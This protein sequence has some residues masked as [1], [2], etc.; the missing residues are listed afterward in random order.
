MPNLYILDVGH[1]NSTVLVDTDGVVVVDAGRRDSLKIFLLEHGIT[2]IDVLL[3]S[4]SDIDHIGGAIDIL[5]E[6]CIDVKL[7][8]FNSDIKKKN[9]E[10]FRRLV[11]LADKI[12]AEKKA[13]N[14]PGLD[15]DVSLTSNLNGKLDRGKINIEI[16]APSWPLAAFA[17][18]G[19]DEDGRLIQS[20]SISS[21]IRMT[22]DGEKIILL[23]G[24]LDHIGL[25]D[26]KKN[27]DKSRISDVNA[28]IIVYPH[29]GGKSGAPVEEQFV[30]SLLDFVK[31]S[32]IIFSIASDNKNFP[33]QMVYDTITK[34]FPE[35]EIYA[36]GNSPRLAEKLQ[37]RVKNAA[38]TIHIN[39]QGTKYTMEC[40]FQKNGD[41]A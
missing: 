7:I 14:Q 25:Q 33:N 41:K 37:P 35:L 32:K 22:K 5:E 3:L 4:H 6:G 12:D 26:L 40:N 19:K 18:G 31:P 9:P 1:G 16:L 2:T 8:R 23:P 13:Q 24:D 39:L 34:R 29:H 27:L 30:Q 11:L 15:C 38:G 10:S 21:V 28:Q 17:A 36:T 20:N